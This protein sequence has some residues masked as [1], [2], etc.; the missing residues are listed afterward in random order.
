MNI[1]TR[2]WFGFCF[3]LLAS[4]STVVFADPGNQHP[5]QPEP[6][7]FS[8]ADIVRKEKPAVVNISTTQKTP[9]AE[10][11]LPE[12][13][14]PL[15]DFF[16]KIFP[17]EYKGESL[18]SGFII[19]KNGLI[20]TNNHVIEKADKIIVRLS[21]E[22]EFEAKVIGRDDK[23]DLALI[24]IPHQDN[25][26]TA[27]LGDSDQLDVGEWVVAIGNPF[28]LE[29]TVTVGIVS[30]KGRAIGNGPFDD[31]IQ[32]DASI[33]PGNS[34]GPL[35]NTNGEVIG[36]NTAISP[37]GQGIGF[38]IPI[39]QVKKVLD[40]LETYGKITRG[41]LGVMIQELN[42]DLARSFHLKSKNGAL[43]SDVFENSPAFKAGLQ[44]GDVI[45]EFDGKEI[46]QMRT[47]PLIVAETPVGKEV[48]LKTVRDGQERT[49]LIRVGPM[50]DKGEK[51]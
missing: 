18:G 35:F 45:V 25:L 10:S 29:Q 49:V 11:P 2:T 48:K 14:P 30:A 41:W 32:T 16:G 5:L 51:K 42:D 4:G 3:A 47:L 1:Q 50:E 15:G 28:G 20:L 33:N 19:K 43:I 9:A 34:G 21:D 24:K 31:Y 13:H 23:T 46:V 38:A 40:Q 12:D 8:F 6:K 36:I 39:N 22:R 37:S 26:P 17:K 27:R 44:R 7:F